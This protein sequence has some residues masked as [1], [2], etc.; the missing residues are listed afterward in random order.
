[1]GDAMPKDT[2][3]CNRRE[4]EDVFLLEG[5]VCGIRRDRSTRAAFGTDL[6]NLHCIATTPT[7]SAWADCLRSL[8]RNLG[9][10]GLRLASHEIDALR[11]FFKS[12]SKWEQ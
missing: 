11:W 6:H 1:M 4:L 3:R 9:I 7:C 8:S 10:Y 12:G 2:Q 5:S